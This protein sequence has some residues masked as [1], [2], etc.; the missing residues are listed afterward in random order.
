[1]AQPQAPDSRATATG[2]AEASAT[3]TGDLDRALDRVLARPEF[4]WRLPREKGTEEDR[5]LVG[6]VVDTLSRWSRAALDGLD[7]LTSWLRGWW[8]PATG[9]SGESGLGWIGSTYVWLGLLAAAVLIAAVLLYRRRRAPEPSEA[10]AATPV[11]LDPMADAAAAAAAAPEEWLARAD[12]LLRA[13]DSRYAVRALYLASLSLL[14]HREL[15]QPE[16][17]K[18]NH[19]YLIELRRRARERPQL[20]DLFAACSDAFERVWYGHHPATD[21]LVTWF[22]AQHG[23][24]VAHAS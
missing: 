20:G 11:A 24:L 7:R 6:M 10:V 16:R 23:Q 15:L 21:E 9:A 22:R 5:G 1:M 12:E 14:V 17:S 3:A 13:G 18:S 19:D 8:R 2:G 4:A